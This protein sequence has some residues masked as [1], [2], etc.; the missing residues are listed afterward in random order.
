MAEKMTR[1]ELKAP[2]KFTVTA[3]GW[4]EKARQHPR[5]TLAGIGGL[6]V[7]LLVLGA[8]LDSGGIDVDPA[9]GG[10]LSQ[11]LAIG[12]RPV[13]EGEGEASFATEEERRKAFAEALEAVRRD[14]PK[15]PA[16]VTATLALADLRYAEGRHEEAIA[17]Y[18]AY[19][20]RTK[21]PHRRVLALEGKAMAL[22]AK[23]DLD[24]AIAAFDALAGAGA[25]AKGLFG[26]A[27]LL[28]RQGKWSE[29]RAAWTTLKEN[30]GLTYE[31]REAGQRLARLNLE[32]PDAQ[33]G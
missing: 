26:K 16:A 1:R 33:E 5:E 21:E 2:D 3:G 24:A 19:L 17:L 27:R 4:L 25:E 23:G 6:V 22:E 11:A 29:A 31:G 20:A 13:G 9:S 14:H 15:S 30:H 8:L 10:A 28:E 18:D 7:V 12:E 32:H